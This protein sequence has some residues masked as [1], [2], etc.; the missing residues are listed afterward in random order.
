MD[1]VERL[2]EWLPL[3]EGW[4]TRLCDQGGMF[5]LYFMTWG[6]GG[7]ET[8][9]MLASTLSL[10]SRSLAN[11]SRRCLTSKQLMYEK[12]GD[13]LKVLELKTVEIPE[14]LEVNEVRV[15][16]LA[17]PINPA[18]INQVQGVYPI[19]PPLPAVGGS[20]G[21]A[22]V[23]AVG[24]GVVDLQP[25]DWV[26]AAHSGLGC[27]RTRAI[28]TE[29]DVI[30][31][32]KD[33]P[34]EAA[35][36]FQVNPPTAY[37]MLKDF[38]DLRSGDLVVQNAANSAVGRAVIQAG[39]IIAHAR[40]IRTVNVVRKRPN[41]DELVAELK[42]LGADEVFTE[43]QMLKEI[44]GKAKGAKLALNC[45]GGRSALMLA[46][47]LTKKGVMVTYGGMS[48]QPLQQREEMF[49]EL[50]EMVRTGRFKTPHF[51]KRELKDWQKALTD[52][53]SSADK[54]QLFQREE[55]FRELGEMVRTGRFKTPHFQKRELKDWQKALTDAVS[56]ADKKQLFVY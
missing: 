53:V 10:V 30:K 34:F 26:V 32:E 19:K 20:E 9:Q 47:C 15:K 7:G 3:A 55:M 36:T 54:K 2:S 37:R 1:G 12:Y 31:I 14:K 42:S 28:Y 46:S 43:E 40:R 17:A 5:Y 8:V 21:F 50:G 33:I 35:A 23:E 38:V 44:K 45:V 13:P 51:Q 52:A 4:I 18:D 56:S 48:K 27:W 39:V 6:E 29:N 16:W 11:T 25:G 41:I 22:E 24:A 49:R